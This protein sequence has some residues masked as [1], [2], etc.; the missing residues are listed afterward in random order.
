M[1]YRLAICLLAISFAVQFQR[2]RADESRPRIIVLTDITNEPDDQESLVRFLVYA[3]EFEVEGLIATTSTWLRDRTS[4]KN[5]ADCVMA[6]DKVKPKLSQHAEGYPT[7]GHL[8]AVTSEGYPA[9]GMSGVGEGKDTEG[10]YR[11]IDVVDREDP[12]PIWVTAWGGANC[13]AQA[14]WKVRETRTAD[15]LA[16]FVSKL[17]VYTIS[18]QDDSGPWMRREFPDLFFV[19]SPSGERA[20]EY[21]DATW[22]GISGDE[23]YLNGPGFKINMVSNE[24]LIK[25]VRE[26]HGPLGAM[27]PKWEYI[28]EG[29]TPS[30]MNLINNGLGSHVSPGYGGWGGRYFLKR[31]YGYP[32][33]FWTNTRD[34]VATPDGKRHV[35]N[36][37]T[38]WRWREDFQRD[39][40]A[41]MDWCVKEPQ[42]ANHN[43]TAVLEGDATKAVLHRSAKLG[44]TIELTAEGSKDPDGNKLTYTWFHYPEAGRDL[45]SKHDLWNVPIENSNAAVCEVRI[46]E[47]LPK[48]KRNVHV[49]LKVTDDGTPNL[50]SYRRVILQVGE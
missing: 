30:F 41:R 7:K 14:L 5:I 3:N 44:E 43:P 42:E 49:I 8:D 1:N 29:D 16:S 23:Y 37:A 6:Y 39:F 19:V 32:G 46:P 27:Y 22:T 18:D 24:W 12:R 2:A 28:M 45:Q 50:C 15:E 34:A 35:G 21:Q 10:S 20:S 48:N 31:I 4:V 38:I 33:K 11:I 26:D 36:T 9:F 25:N 40:A 47:D 13:L 17:R